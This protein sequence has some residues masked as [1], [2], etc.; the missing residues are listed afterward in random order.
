MDKMKTVPRRRKSDTTKKEDF[1]RSRLLEWRTKFMEVR[2]QRNDLAAKLEAAEEKIQR[3]EKNDF[4]ES[5]KDPKAKLETAEEKKQNLT[6]PVSSPLQG[7]SNDCCSEQGTSSSN[8]QTAENRLQVQ[9]EIDDETMKILKEELEAYNLISNNYSA[10]VK[11]MKEEDGNDVLTQSSSSIP[12]PELGLDLNWDAETKVESEMLEGRAERLASELE[13]C[14]NELKIIQRD[15]AMAKEEIATLK[16]ERKIQA[17]EH[18]MLLDIADRQR[19]ISA[20]AKDKIANDLASSQDELKAT[21]QDFETQIQEYKR[22][23]ESS[24]IE[25]EASTCRAKMPEMTLTVSMDDKELADKIAGLNAELGNLRKDLEEAR[26]QSS[27][28]DMDNGIL[29]AQQLIYDDEI[30]RLETELSLAK[31]N[32]QELRENSSKTQQKFE[33]NEQIL[34][35]VTKKLRRRNHNIKTAR[36]A[37]QKLKKQ[38]CDMRAEGK[39]MRSDTSSLA[40]LSEKI[41]TLTED[42]RKKKD[43]V[44]CLEAALQKSRIWEHQTGIRLEKCASELMAEREKRK[45]SEY[46]LRHECEL[47]KEEMKLLQ[48]QID[49]TKKELSDAL[50]DKNKFENSAKKFEQRIAE[51]EKEILR[52]H[53]EVAQS[54]TIIEDFGHQKSEYDAKILELSREKTASEVKI[55]H[56]SKQ[57]SEYKEEFNN[58]FQEK[59]ENEARILEL[60]QQKSE[61]EAKI[62]DIS[63]QKFNCEVK[64]QELYLER[65]KSETKIQ[66][67]ALQK[68]EYEAKIQELCREKCENEARILEF[69]N[70]KSA[71]VSNE[72]R[73]RIKI[74]IEDPIR[75]RNKLIQDKAQ[76]QSLID[77]SE[78]RARILEQRAITAEAQVEKLKADKTLAESKIRDLSAQSQDFS[79]QKS[80]FE[81]KIEKYS[82]ENCEYKH[83][84]RKFSEEKSRYETRI[85]EASR[86]KSNYEARIQGYCK[87][88]SKLEI[89][90]QELSNQMVK[91]QDQI[92]ELSREKSEQHSKIAYEKAQYE[93]RIQALFIQKTEYEAKIREFSLERSGYEARIQEASRQKSDYETKINVICEEKSELGIKIQELSNQKLKYEDE[94]RELKEHVKNS[95]EGDLLADVLQFAEQQGEYEVKIQELNREKSEYEAKIQEL[96]K[97]MSEYEAKFQDYSNEK[98]EYESRIQ[99]FEKKMSDHEEK[100]KQLCAKKSEY[101]AQ[102]KEYSDENSEY[103]A[104][105]Q[106]YSEEKSGYEARIQE[107]LRK[108]SAF[109][110]Q[111][112]KLF[113]GKCENPRRNPRRKPEK[114]QDYSQQMTV[115][116]S[117]LS[118]QK[119]EYEEEIRELK[120]KIKKCG[121][122]GNIISSKLR[123]MEENA[124][125]SEQLVAEL[126]AKLVEAGRK[127]LQWHEFE[128]NFGQ[129]MP[130]LLTGETG[131]QSVS[132]STLL[133]DLQKRISAL[134]KSLE[135]KRE[136]VK[137]LEAEKCLAYTK[138]VELSLQKSRLEEEIEK[139][140]KLKA[141]AERNARGFATRNAQLR[142]K[143]AAFEIEKAKFNAKVNEVEAKFENSAHNA[144]LVFELQAK[145]EQA[146]RRE[147]AWSEFQRNFGQ[148]S[149]YMEQ[150]GS[151]ISVPPNNKRPFDNLAVNIDAVPKRPYIA[152]EGPSTS[153]GHIPEAIG[154]L[155]P[156]HNGVIVNDQRPQN[157]LE[158][159]PNVNMPL[160]NQNWLMGHGFNVREPNIADP[161]FALQTFINAFVPRDYG[162]YLKNPTTSSPD[163]TS[164]HEPAVNTSNSSSENDEIDIIRVESME[165]SPK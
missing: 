124:G 134:T 57:L 115:Y 70:Q 39:K 88:K 74:E 120:E 139:T 150:L 61:Y 42:L 108:I 46:Y 119:A 47:H 105:I 104:Q 41:H 140:L 29:K 34:S 21:R 146:R 35:L 101:E 156:R 60:S 109:E 116:E 114:I 154:N 163:S 4:S 103:I 63:E 73:G 136:L 5:N 28:L 40:D 107:L 18:K 31:Q 123:K 15:F 118:Q 83:K 38:I 94:I 100:V 129:L 14:Q 149:V 49:K 87:E 92:R 22:Q 48:D 23:L 128:K 122:N 113:Q 102:I 131:A 44:R 69:S 111:V 95:E 8:L 145:L 37:I 153:H 121:E 144:R 79:R 71:K 25:P 13:N 141:K 147:S 96:S 80:E 76:M 82:Q 97:Q 155:F 157:P 11:N 67:F 3:L 98:S 84:I 81:A 85:Q 162:L 54:E 27:H 66:E 143:V 33:D 148:L 75:R 6:D 90:I 151:Q 130:Q 89:K 138:T 32:E 117:K 52:L 110:E 159:M 65:S 50:D 132:W 24:E 127:E 125:K 77:K 30:Q 10:D 93:A 43:V 9:M 1:D 45:A 91:Y 12:S 135:E 99:E 164:H 126:R 7:S 158:P 64:I 19:N 160:M 16:E 161:D 142:S 68:A 59:S 56:L 20:N 53:G 86:Q 152:A 62:E 72:K 36:R 2:K 112:E 51:S 133:D 137:I 55:R 106:E 165:N 78:R 58:L 26:Q 17:Q